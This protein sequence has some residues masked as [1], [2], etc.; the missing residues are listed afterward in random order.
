[1]KNIQTFFAY[2]PDD[3]EEIRS[4][5][6]TIF[7]VAGACTF[8]GLVWAAMYYVIFGWTFTTFLP[9]LFTF[10]VGPALIISHRTKNH[11]YAV[12]AQIICIMYIGAGIQWSIGGIFDSGLVLLWAFIGPIVALMFF[13]IRKSLV[14]LTLYLINIF[15]TVFNDPYFAANRLEVTDGVK[16]FFFLMNLGI[17]SIVVFVFASYFV[18]SALTER[19]RANR[20]LLN[21][22][23]K[24]IAALLKTKSATIA[25]PIDSASVL[26]ADIVGFTPFFAQL[27]P[28][29][30]VAW[31]NDVFSILDDLADKYN[32]EKIK[33]IGD[34]YMVASGIP[35]PNPD[36]AK[37]IA[38]FALEMNQKLEDIPTKKDHPIQFRVGIH[39][40]PFVA[41]VIGKSKF[42]YDIW[43]DT[44]N[45]ASRMESHSE[46]GKIQ[47]TKATYDLIKDEFDCQ[48]RGKIIIK[49]K[50]E[51][52][53][54][55][56]LSK[57]GN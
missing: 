48:S 41:G 22:L 30:A 35:T 49:G 54:W 57:K 27:D 15:I 29:E 18:N 13:P 38:K 11:H 45:T 42:Q 5:K 4:E 25:D 8:F 46:A 21:I 47:I 43:G 24:E 17:A 36:H 52:E 20:L 2:H 19:A 50:G 53:T 32:L 14:W 55:F 10:I 26:F 56:L 16:S 40:G 28:E 9:L 23:P 39:S 3:T 34:N 6:F 1:M 44:V 7:L 51:M 31:L 37:N 33:T 12:Y